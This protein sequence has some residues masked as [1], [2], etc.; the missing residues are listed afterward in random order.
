MNSSLVVNNPFFVLNVYCMLDELVKGKFSLSEISVFKS[1]DSK[2]VDEKVPIRCQDVTVY[3]SM[4]EWE[5]L[6]GH[7]DLYKDVMMEDPQPLTSPALSSKRT[8]PERCPRPLLPQDCKQE[9]PDVPQ[10]VF[11]PALSTGDCIES[12]DGNLLSS[13]FKTDEKSITHHTYEEHAAVPNIPAV[14]PRKASSSD[15]FKQVQ[16]S[17]LSQ[18]CKQNKSY[19]RDVE[20][21]TAPTRVK[22]FSCSK[23]GKCFTRKSSLNIHQKTHT[24]K[25][26]FSCPECGKCFTQKITLANHQKYHTG[27]K[28][29]SCS[30]CGKCFIQK[31]DLVR[32]QRCHTGEKPFSC[33]ECGKCFIQKSAFVRHQRFHTV[34]KPFSCSECEKCFIQKSDLVVHQRCH[35]GEKPFSCSDCGKCFIRKST[36]VQHQRFHTRD[37]PFSCSECGKCFIWKSDLVVHQRCHT[38][39]KPFS[40]SE[41]HKCFIKKSDLVVHQRCHTGEKPFSCSDCGKCFIRKANLVRHQRF[42]TGEKPFSCSECGK[43]FIRKLDLVRHQRCHTGEKPFSCSECGKSF[44]Q[45]SDLVVHQRCHTGEKPFSCSDCGKCFIRKSN[46]VRHQR[47]HTGEKPFSCSECGKCFIQK[48]NLVRHQRF[49]TGEKPFSCSECGKCFIQKSNLVQHQRSHTG[50]MLFSCPECGKCFTRKSRLVY[51]KKN[52][53]IEYLG[54]VVSADGVRPAESKIQAFQGWPT[55]RTV[56]DARAFLGLAGYY[57]QFVND[58]AKMCEPLN[59]LLRGTSQGP[60]N[61]PIQWTDRQQQAFDQIWAALIQAPLL[62]YALF[63]RPFTLYTDGSLHGLRAVLAQK[64]EGRERVVAYASRSLRDTERNPDNYTSFK[65]EMLALVWAMTEKF[66]E[67]LLGSKVLVITDNNLLAHLENAKLGAL[68]QRWVARMS[69]FNY[70]IRFRSGKGNSN[71]DALPQVTRDAPGCEVDEDLE[72]TEIPNL[73]SGHH[74]CLVMTD[75]FTK[76]AVVVP[77]RDQ[78]AESAAEVICKHFILT[79]G[80]SQRL[81]SGQGACFQGKLVTELLQVYGIIQLRTTPYHPQGNGACEQFNH[82]L[83]QMLRTL[84]QQQKARWTEFIP[85]LVWAYNNKVHS[86]NRFTPYMMMFG[87]PRKKVEELNLSV[88]GELEYCTASEWVQSH[89]WNLR[90]IHRIVGE[91]VRDHPHRNRGLVHGDEFLVGE[92][93]SEYA[94]KGF[95]HELNQNQMNIKVTHHYSQSDVDFLDVHVFKDHAGFLQTEPERCPRPLLPQDCKQ[96]D[97]DVPQDHQGEDLPHINTTETYVRGDERSKEEIPTDNRPDDCTSRSVAQLTSSVFKSNDLDMPQDVTEVNAIAPDIAS[98]LQSKDISSHSFEPTSDLSQTIKKNK[99]HKT[100]IQNR[101]A[102]TVKTSFSTLESEKILNKIHTGEKRFSSESFS[103][104]RTH[105]G[106]KP[107]SCSECGKCFT[108]KSLLVIHQRTHTGEKPFSC[109][110]CGKCFAHKQHFVSHQ[111]T[112]TGEKPFSCS[113]CGKC[114]AQKSL[115]V[116]HQRTHTGEKPFSCSECGKCFAHKQ[117]FVSHQR[118]HTGEKPFSCLE[119]GKCYAWKSELVAHQKTHTGEKPFSCSKCGK[120]FA[121]KQHFVTHQ[122]THTGEKP[123]SCSECGKCFTQKSVLVKHQRTHTGEKPYSCSECGKCFIQKSQLVGHQRTHTEKSFS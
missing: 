64:Q 6:E 76:F 75:H 56:R 34:E 25:K 3:F 85:E 23:C 26:P 82:T 27:E 14:L 10:D 19:R 43:W 121:H 51:H 86:T 99:S 32:H 16:N 78:T 49:H 104:Q 70:P 93:G 120:C 88:P 66:A 24:G 35:T 42:H 110:E 119:C 31:S 8:T 117:H 102:L 98:S 113:E 108:Q 41:C 115:L 81:H 57:R 20:H 84:E 50:E 38:G 100:S 79:Y 92:R 87:R 90:E 55:P 63:D 45:K 123:F 89:Q 48:S 68:K 9:D 103:Y 83:L 39:E 112:H 54:H 17:N 109:S 73:R 44:F 72:D 61:Q 59:E 65:L 62:A 29:F 105:T 46:L 4:E 33:S 15:L 80:C 28:P 5:Y 1:V 118:T 40:C 91:E 2:S 36:L 74:S 21:E 22:P 11:P 122:R 116:I 67:Y 69:K 13:E 12:S 106:E 94:L 101:N 114:F 52:T 30:E 96:E 58:F 18:N 47:F 71:A 95:L 77:T 111:R 60:R 107:F 37:K 53:Q 7:K 97:P